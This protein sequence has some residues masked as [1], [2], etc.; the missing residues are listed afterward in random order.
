MNRVR[1]G[2]GKPKLSQFRNQV[3]LVCSHFGRFA[4]LFSPPKKCQIRPKFS[5]GPKCVHLLP[6]NNPIFLLCGNYIATNASPGFDIDRGEWTPT[7]PWIGGAPPANGGPNQHP[8]GGVPGP[9][10]NV[11]NFPALCA[12][13]F[14]HLANFYPEGA[15]NGIFGECWLSGE[16]N[17]GHRRESPTPPPWR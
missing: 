4:G 3:N 11:K 6:D 15:E 12:E 5:L 1:V 7:P 17:L 13:S 2:I 9:P 10:K 16:P 8:G 14:V